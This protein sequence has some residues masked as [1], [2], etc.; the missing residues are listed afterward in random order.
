MKHQQGV[1]SPRVTKTYFRTFYDF[2]FNNVEK[3]DS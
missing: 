2:F 3:I 1:K